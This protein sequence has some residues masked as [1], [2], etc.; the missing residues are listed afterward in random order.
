MNEQEMREVLIRHDEQLK[1]VPRLTEAVNRL[2]EELHIAN[3]RANAIAACIGIMGSII[4]CLGTWAVMIH[5]G[6]K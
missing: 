3:A 1:T 2:S 5:F 6:G 4:G